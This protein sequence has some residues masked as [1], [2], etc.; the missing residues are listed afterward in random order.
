MSLKRRLESQIYNFRYAL[1]TI[2]VPEWVTGMR[3][4]VI[5]TAAFVFFTGAYIIQTSAGA[6]SG[7]DVH[8]LESQV[9]SLQ[10]D[11]QK[12]QTEVVTYDSIGSIQKRAQ[13]TNMVAVG[14]IK[15]LTSA[16]L[17][18]AVR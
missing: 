18:V 1:T 11:I 7:Y 16:G 3:T 5:L 4:R 17:A 8:T 14:E 2:H 13:E 9:S 6:V 15:H 10:S 12:L